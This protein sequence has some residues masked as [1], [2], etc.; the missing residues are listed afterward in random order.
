M[1]RQVDKREQ[2][3][4]HPNGFNLDKIGS[5]DCWYGIGDN[6][7]S[8]MISAR[9][10]F[11]ACNSYSY[12]EPDISY[13]PPTNCPH[14]VHQELS[15]VPYPR[16]ALPCVLPEDPVYPCLHESRHLHASRRPR[17]CGGRFANTKKLESPDTPTS[18]ASHEESNIK[19]N[20]THSQTLNDG[21]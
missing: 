4:F 19:G 1:Q 5:Q 9:S 7:A 20:S 12:V 11:S 21:E 15:G 13:S 17:G 14:L 6:Y 18:N 10:T 16:T 2:H 3:E 8:P